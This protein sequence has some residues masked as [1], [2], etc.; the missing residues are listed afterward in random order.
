MS[1]AI[2]AYHSVTNSPE[3]REMERLREKAGHD[4]AQALHHAEQKGIE[5][6]ALNLLKSGMPTG[7]IIQLTGL[8][9][10]ELRKL[11]I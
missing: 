8:S 11:I 10:S 5:K 3:Y 2:N 1:E 9:Q 4:E 6:I 7:Q